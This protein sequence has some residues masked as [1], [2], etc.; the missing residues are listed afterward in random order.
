M[1][2]VVEPV[3]QQQDLG[4]GDVGQLVKQGADRRVVADALGRHNVLHQPG[5]LGGYGCRAGP[6]YGRPARQQRGVRLERG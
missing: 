3:V 4:V 2:V 1:Q 6:N 5:G